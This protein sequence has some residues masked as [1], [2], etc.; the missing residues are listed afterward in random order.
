MCGLCYDSTCDGLTHYRAQGTGQKSGSGFVAEAV[1]DG[2]VD[3]LNRGDSSWNAAS[4]IT[5]TFYETI[6]NY[7]VGSSEY[8]GFSAFNEQQVDMAKLA[9]SVWGDVAAV[10][11]WEMESGYS[12]ISFANSDT[13]SSY[14]AAHAYMPS[15]AEWGGDVWV[16][17]DLG[18]NVNPEVGSYGFAVLVH[19]I[20][21]ALGQPHPG[22]YNASA[23]SLSYARNA[24]YKEDSAQYT[25]MSYWDETNTGADFDGHS[26]QTPMLHDILAIQ[27]KYG[28]NLTTRT[29]DTVYG[30]NSN[31]E[32]PVFDFELNEHPVL[33]I[34]DA[35][36][37]DTIDLSG[38]S[39]DSILNLNSGEF[40]SVA[41]LVK[42]LSIAYGAEIEHAITGDG[43]DIIIGNELD[44][45]VDAGTGS[46]TFGLNVDQ[47][48]A[49]ML[50]F[51]DGRIVI[52]SDQGIDQITN[53]DSILFTDVDVALVGVEVH[54]ILDYAASYDDLSEAFGSNE[55]LLYEHL[56]T[57]G[58]SEGRTISF[59]A[60]DYIASH[61]DLIN[62]FGA[63]KEAGA[64]HYMEFGRLEGRTITFD[65]N[66]FLD[67]H[68]DLQMAMG[69]NENPAQYFIEL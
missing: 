39:E 7:A 64:K 51:D 45:I 14:S 15:Y 21:H 16:N 44:N 59:S 31:T 42:N 49:N 4:P 25:I 69:V 28:A 24:E 63:D 10:T 9:L 66:E 6:P 13:L 48:D 55:E 65:P 46:D 34:W 36:G 1:L 3:Q 11:F 5:F 58:M 22:D 67:A 68:P 8:R 27:A 17:S 60:L 61:E 2:I 56:I 26:A 37:I 23:G 43:D 30:F 38:F 52:S 35:G 47:I 57:N 19:E 62:S 33:S 40:S 20:G 32:S 29:G 18:Y 41:G 12:K 54:S 53:V 50:V